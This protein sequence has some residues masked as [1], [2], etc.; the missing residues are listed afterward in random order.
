V[1]DAAEYLG[2]SVNAVRMRVRRGTLASEKDDKGNV[3]VLVE[4]YSTDDSETARQT[5]Q[6]TSG[7][8]GDLREQVAY[9]REIIA[10]RDEELRRKDT[11]IMQMAQ[12]IPELEATREEPPQEEPQPGEDQSSAPP[13]RGWEEENADAPPQGFSARFRR[14]LRGR[15]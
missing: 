10:T 7:Q 14:W 3:W 9:L 8:V 15:S 11:I 1:L 12:R 2:V 6:E 4:D 5:N 13:Q